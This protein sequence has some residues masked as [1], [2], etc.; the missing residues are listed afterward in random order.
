MDAVAMYISEG[1]NRARNGAFA[2][3]V[4]FWDHVGRSFSRISVYTESARCVPT[5]RRPGGTEYELDRTRLPN[6]GHHPPDLV[7]SAVTICS[8]G[9]ASAEWTFHASERE[10]ERD[11]AA[12]RVFI[13]ATI[14]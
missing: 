11:Q 3:T 2:A 9:R 1:A 6:A 5:A 7:S 4:H 14:W 12:T 10:P 8:G 13:D